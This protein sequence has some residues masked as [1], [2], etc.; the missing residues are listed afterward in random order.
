MDSIVYSLI[1]DLNSLIFKLANCQLPTANC[2]YLPSSYNFSTASQLTIFQK[3]PMYS[4]R[5]F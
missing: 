5:R 2:I 4:V 3:F 1:F